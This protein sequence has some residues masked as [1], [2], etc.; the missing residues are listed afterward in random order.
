MES[1]TWFGGFYL[2]VAAFTFL[3]QLALIGRPREPL[4]LGDVMVWVFVQGLY[5]WGLFTVGVTR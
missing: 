5:I 2:A 3:M 4:S 1:V